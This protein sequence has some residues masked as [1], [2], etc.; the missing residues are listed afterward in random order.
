MKSYVHLSEGFRSLRAYRDIRQGETILELP[1]T[2]IDK[3]DKY[4]IEVYPGVHIECDESPVGSLNHS[5]EPNAAVKGNRIIAWSCIKRGDEITLDYKRT[6]SS[7]STPFDCECGSKYCRG[8]IE[9]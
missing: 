9:W 5:C 8:R 2:V 1:T 4:S 7:I 6:E 3:P